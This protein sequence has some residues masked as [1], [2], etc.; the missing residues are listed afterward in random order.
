MLKVSSG[1]SI[2]N[3]HP[4]KVNIKQQFRDINLMKVSRID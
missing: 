3:T 2:F 4:G 1:I